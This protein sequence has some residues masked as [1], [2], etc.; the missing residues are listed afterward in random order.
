MRHT[1]RRDGHLLYREARFAQY[2]DG[3]VL[4]SIFA[5]P[6]EVPVTPELRCC[7]TRMN[8]WECTERWQA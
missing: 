2:R 1:V 6:A 5:L 3:L 7:G 8:C 4:V